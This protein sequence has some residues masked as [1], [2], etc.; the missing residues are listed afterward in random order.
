MLCKEPRAELLPRE[1][2]NKA[3]RGGLC[4]EVAGVTGRKFTRVFQGL[5]V[6]VLSHQAPHPKA[7]RLWQD[8]VGDTQLIHSTM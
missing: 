7:F 2:H 5:C 4:D 3:H 1:T 8:G 6:P